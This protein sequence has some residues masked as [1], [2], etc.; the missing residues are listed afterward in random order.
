[1]EEKE[2]EFKTITLEVDAW[3]KLAMKKIALR[4]KNFSETIEYLIKGDEEE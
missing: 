4:H 3:E 2:K 1:M